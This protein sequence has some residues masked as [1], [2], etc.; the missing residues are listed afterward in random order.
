MSALSCTAFLGDCFV[1]FTAYSHSSSEYRHGISLRRGL[2]PLKI[3]SEPQF[4]QSVRIAGASAL[5][6]LSSGSPQ[7][8][9]IGGAAQDQS[10]RTH[11]V[12][13]VNRILEIARS[14]AREPGFRCHLARDRFGK[15]QRAEAQTARFRQRRGHATEYRE[16]VHHR[17]KRIVFEIFLERRLAVNVGD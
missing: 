9:F 1:E 2:P 11:L 4:D 7:S 5:F 12:I 14:E 13:R 6:T 10:L 16:S 3:G 15:S 17:R 8:P